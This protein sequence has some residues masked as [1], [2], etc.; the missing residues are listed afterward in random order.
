[1]RKSRKIYIVQMLF[2]MFCLVGISFTV[3]AP[4]K[5]AESFKAVYNVKNSSF[6]AKSG[7]DST[8]AIQ[9]A[10]DKAAKNAKAG[11]RVTR[12]EQYKTCGRGGGLCGEWR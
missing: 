3:K 7:K 1:M 5:A 9:K 11:K 4:V 12:A 6:G 10:L 2:V 8:K